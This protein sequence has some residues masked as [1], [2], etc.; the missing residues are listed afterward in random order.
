LK[1]SR[2][3]SESNVLIASTLYV[4]IDARMWPFSPAF[5]PIATPASYVSPSP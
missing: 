3:C 1:K 5:V 2:S 4:S